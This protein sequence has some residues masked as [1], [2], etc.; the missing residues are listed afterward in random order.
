MC[1]LYNNFGLWYLVV[2]VL[3]NFLFSGLTNIF[4]T[5]GNIIFHRKK[6]DNCNDIFINLFTLNEVIK[7]LHTKKNKCYRY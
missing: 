1:E 4:L 5:L 2:T 3:K 7:K 6:F